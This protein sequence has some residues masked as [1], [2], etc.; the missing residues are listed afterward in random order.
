MGNNCTILYLSRKNPLSGKT[1]Q[2]KQ[3]SQ[4]TKAKKKKKN[5]EE[6]EEDEYD[7][8]DEEG[9]EEEEVIGINHICSIDLS[10]CNIYVSCPDILSLILMSIYPRRR[11]KTK[12]RKNQKD[13]NRIATTR[14]KWKI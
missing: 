5:D 9:E 8:E 3:K 13:L 12:K 10:R 4:P 6:E 7:E 11:K 2:G 14:T 1:E